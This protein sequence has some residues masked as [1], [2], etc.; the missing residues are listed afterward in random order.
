M[1]VSPANIFDLK[2]RQVRASKGYL[3]FR[4]YEDGWL[5]RHTMYAGGQEKIEG[6]DV[7]TACRFANDRLG[8]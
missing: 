4:L 7:W 5:V 6:A 1:N 3:T 8:A 2:D